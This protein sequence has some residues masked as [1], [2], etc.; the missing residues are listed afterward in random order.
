MLKRILF[1]VLAFGVA[2][3]GATGLVVMRAKRAAAAA[4]PAVPDSTHTGRDSSAATDSSAKR[5]LAAAA[6]DSAPVPLAAALPPRDS[7]RPVASKVSRTADS[8]VAPAPTTPVVP[9]APAAARPA[10]IAPVTAILAGGRL[11]K[12]FGA[13]SARDA[14]KVLEQMDDADIK[15][16]LGRLND[17]KAAEILALIPAPRAAIIS[18]AALAAPGPV[19]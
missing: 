13:M 8:V 11:S 10:P 5:A 6:K 15:E 1:F 3:G 12:I 19:K 17:K 9:G 14:A 18:K 7:V 2:L 16:I 4:T